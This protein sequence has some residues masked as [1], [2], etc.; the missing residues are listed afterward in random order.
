MA[1]IDIKELRYSQTP[2]YNFVVEIKS[3]IK[4]ILR[5]SIVMFDWKL[6][7]KLYNKAVV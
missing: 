3:N 2:R 1:Q 7:I 5:L 6:H 4:V